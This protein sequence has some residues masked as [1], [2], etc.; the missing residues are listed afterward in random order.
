[1]IAKKILGSCVRKRG[2]WHLWGHSWEIDCDD[3]CPL[4]RDVLEYAKVNG[5]KHDTEFVTN[6]MLVGY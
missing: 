5:R 3:N 2:I 1:M 6:G 4:L